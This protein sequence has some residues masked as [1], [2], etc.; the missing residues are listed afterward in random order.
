MLNNLAKSIEE[1]DNARNENKVI[2]N[3]L[4]DM[5]KP[6]SD[7]KPLHINS[8]QELLNQKTSAPNKEGI[9]QLSYLNMLLKPPRSKKRVLIFCSIVVIIFAVASSLPFLVDSL[10]SS[11]GSLT[12]VSFIPIHN[13]VQIFRAREAS[14]RGRVEDKTASMM[15]QVF[16]SIKTTSKYHYPR[17]VILLETW[18]SLVKGST[19]V[20]TDKVEGDT[21]L[22]RRMGDHLVETN[23]SSTHHR[24]SLCCKMEQEFEHFLRS[25][26]QWWC[27]FD[28]DNF[29]NVDSLSRLL[30]RHDPSLPWYL[31]K[32][33]TAS[34]LRVMTSSGNSSFWFAT[35]GAGFCVSRTLALKMAPHVV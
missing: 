19:W 18:V 23:C 35:G 5:N 22:R 15:S 11:P 13:V 14:Y 21:E 31:G 16:I 28:D 34:P 10:R 30:A 24:L 2:T 7:I 26:R 27:H 3:D 1:N 4:S 20:F 6:I 32:T 25:G 17:L 29:V 9:S 12:S 8:L 33:S